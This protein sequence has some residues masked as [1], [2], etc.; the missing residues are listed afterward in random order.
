MR[1]HI[2]NLFVA[3]SLFAAPLALIAH[4]HEEG[5]KPAKDAAEH[6]HNAHQA[7]E[8]DEVKTGIVMMEGEFV[9][10]GCYAIHQ[11]QGPDHAECAERCAAAGAP[12]AL[13]NAKDG[14]LYLVITE[15]HFVN[16]AGPVLGKLGKKVKVQAK[17]LK[18]AN[19]TMIVPI[20][21]ELANGNAGKPA[22]KR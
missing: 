8:K 20:K 7:G 1:R 16:A 22:D 12:V 9:E 15:D 6:D 11:S 17:V 13:K 19:L 4:E 5:K 10:V 3:V 2:F 18:T 14:K 21:V